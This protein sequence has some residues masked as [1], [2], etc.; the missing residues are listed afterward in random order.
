MG[1]GIPKAFD[2]LFEGL[3]DGRF[4]CPGGCRNYEEVA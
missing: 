1:D 2:S 3:D 4:P